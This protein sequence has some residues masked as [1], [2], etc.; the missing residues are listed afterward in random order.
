MA[1]LNIFSKKPIK[2]KETP[3]TKIVA[4]H[5]EKNSLVIAELISLGIEVEFKQ[6]PTA[7]YLVGEIA[8]ERKTISDF[9]SSM[10]NKRIFFQLKSLKQ[11]DRCLFII[12]SYQDLDLSESSLNENAIRGLI[13]SISL[14]NKIPI[15]FTKDPKDTALYLSLITKKKKSEFSLRAKLSLSD[16]D[17]LQFILEGFPSIGPITAKKLLEKYKT[18]KNIINVPE[19]EIKILLG[20]KAEKFLELIN[21]EHARK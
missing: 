17:R 19:E 15:I 10:I 11:Y 8:V 7:D 14:E 4:D 2:N 18:I 16:D 20:K 1:F 12:E 6:L 21:K 9:I 3:K 13:L 5:R